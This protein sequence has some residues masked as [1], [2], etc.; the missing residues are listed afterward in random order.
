MVSRLPVDTPDSASPGEIAF[1]CM[2]TA[3]ELSV[4]SQQIAEVTRK[5]TTLAIVYDYTLHGL[6]RVP[7]MTNCVHCSF[8]RRNYPL[9][10]DASLGAGK[11]SFHRY[12]PNIYFMSCTQCIRA[13]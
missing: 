9:K 8:E 4:T 6:G 12:T 3:N 1:V 5:D 13:L 11:L 2:L 7:E 10:M